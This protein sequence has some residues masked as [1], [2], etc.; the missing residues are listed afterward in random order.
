MTEILPLKE[1]FPAESYHLDYYAR[2]QDQPY[3]ELVI[4][5][6]LEKVQQKFS[7]LLKNNE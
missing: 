2:N 3:C 1:F 7:N 6:K 5:P 4:N